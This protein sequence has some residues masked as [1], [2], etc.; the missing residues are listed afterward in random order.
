MFESTVTIEA[1]VLM[2][3]RIIE[4]HLTKQLITIGVQKGMLTH[5]RENQEQFKE[6]QLIQDHIF[7]LRLCQRIRTICQTIIGQQHQTIIKVIIHQQQSQSRFTI[8]NIISHI[9]STKRQKYIYN[10]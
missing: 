1:M 7:E 10:Q 8:I 6:P 4:R 5:T 9:K 2:F 3:K